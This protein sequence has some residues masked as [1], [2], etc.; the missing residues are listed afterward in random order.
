MLKIN[1]GG[2]INMLKRWPIKY[3][4]KSLSNKF[5][6]YKFNHISKQTAVGNPLKLL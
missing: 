3:F 1:M 6:P 2:F 5:I 4:N